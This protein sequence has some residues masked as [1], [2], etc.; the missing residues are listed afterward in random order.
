MK[1]RIQVRALSRT[2]LGLSIAAGALVAAPILAQTATY[3]SGAPE[4]PDL[5]NLPDWDGLWERDQ[6]NVWDNR[7]PVGQ[8]QEAPYNDEYKALAKDGP[9]GRRGSAFNS[10]PGFLSMLFPMEIQVSRMQMTIMSEN[11]ENYRRIFTDGR[12]H[13]PDTLPSS[14]GH[15]VGKWVNGELHV[16]TCCI[17]E[18]TRLPGNGPHSDALHITE[19][20]YLRDY[21]TLVTEVTVEDPKA[22][23]KP[24]TT[25]KVWHRRPDWEPVEYD[26]E[27]N[28]RDRPAQGGRAAP[29]E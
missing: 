14:N 2:L 23:S 13:T 16:D 6:D 11:K 26:R 27:E 29:T 22:F 3:P 18:D 24:W 10:M 4:I 19:R 17:R 21:K 25:E 12:V 8:S 15:S 7:I 1:Q 20:W 5:A 9:P 28:D